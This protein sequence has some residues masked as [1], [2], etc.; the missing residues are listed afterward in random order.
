MPVIVAAEGSTS[1][2]DTLV[3]AASKVVEFSGTMLNAMVENPIY[4]FYLAAGLV[5]VGLSMV[6]LLKNTARR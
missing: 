1:V 3:T 4:A 2:L 6:A 5:G